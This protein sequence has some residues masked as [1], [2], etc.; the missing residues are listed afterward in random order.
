ML[1]PE[2]LKIE[3]ESKPV[4]HSSLLSLIKGFLA[5]GLLLTLIVLSTDILTGSDLLLQT[6]HGDQVSKT[7]QSERLVAFNALAPLPLNYVELSE[8]PKALDSMQLSPSARHALETKISKQESPQTALASTST[9]NTSA[10]PQPIAAPAQN[11]V[12]LA[13]ITLWDT[14]VEDGDSVKIDSQG[15]S[16]TIVIKKKPETFAIPVPANGIIRIT[17][18]DDGDG[19]GITVGLASGASKAVFPVMS[20]GQVLELKVKV[21]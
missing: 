13:W 15:Y 14:D 10:H 7:E 17:G 6:Q 1:T 21:N 20:I 3:P 9:T 19:G 12:R 18:I 16:R 2:P 4:S 11:Q 5:A 8:V